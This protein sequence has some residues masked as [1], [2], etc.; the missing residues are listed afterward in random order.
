MTITNPQTEQQTDGMAETKRILL[1]EDNELNRKIMETSLKKLG[2]DVH[3][4]MNG[5]E[6]VELA[7]HA[8]FHLILM[9]IQ[10]PRMDGYEAAKKIRIMGILTPIIAITAFNIDDMLNECLASGMNDYLVKPIRKKELVDTIEKWLH[11]L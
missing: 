3:I 6:A 7:S 8:N 9:D 5:E 10:M 1:V 11:N 4:G 2:Y